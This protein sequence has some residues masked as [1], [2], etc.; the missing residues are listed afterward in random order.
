MGINRSVAG[1]AIV[2]ALVAAGC[3]A[4]PTETEVS[5][6][7][8]ASRRNNSKTEQSY[9]A[10][11]PSSEVVPTS[12]ADETPEASD[13]TDDVEAVTDSGAA[14]S[15]FADESAEVAGDDA[16]TTMALG[17]STSDLSDETSAPLDTEPPATGNVCRETAGLCDPMRECAL[18]DCDFET[19][20]KSC[21]Y[22]PGRTYPFMC[23]RAANFE[24]Y[25]PCDADDV[26]AP[27]S[28]CISK[29]TLLKDGSFYRR[30]GAVC[31]ETCRRDAD[32]GEGEWCAQATD[33]NNE[34]IPDLR[35]C[36]RHCDAE[37]DCYVGE[38]DDEVRCS[39][40]VEGGLPSTYECSRA[41]PPNPPTDPA[42]GAQSPN[43]TDSAARDGTNGAELSASFTLHSLRAE[44]AAIECIIG[45]D[46]QA[47]EDCVDNTC[48]RRCE[49]DDECDGTQCVVVSGR[50]TCGA[51][52]E[53]PEGAACALLP[54]NCGCATGETCVL[55][56]GSEPMCSAPGPN[57]AMS[58]CNDS[59]DCDSG[60][61]C[62]GGLCRPLCDPEAQPCNP[63]YG[64]CVLSATRESGDIH[65]CAGTCDP[66]TAPRC[67]PGAVC[68]PG[69]DANHHRQSLCVAERAA[70]SPRS[71]GETCTEDHDCAPGLGCSASAVC[72]SWCRSD[73]DCEGGRVCKFDASIIGPKV[74]RYGESIDDIV[75]LC[76]SPTR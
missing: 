28:V 4:A 54:S 47:K 61:S 42:S 45:D 51:P 26:C 3:S 59:T 8:V 14:A 29:V 48:R 7:G 31:R 52:C 12:V 69:F 44:G 41:R 15:T 66:V 17:A 53:K 6:S 24:P 32:C 30:S 33:E 21:S 22:T 67:G 55:G 58:W 34:P 73:G 1:W 36:H 50:G 64:E 35:V 49:K 74:Q 75:G 20:G 19:T 62:I 60:L 18:S 25:R 40:S 37:S 16:G 68:L 63:Q 38:G 10:V 56:P 65:A 76:G 39:S 11:D 71:A 9:V 46:C 27:G 23:V 5:G 2:T 43:D 13:T 57:G 70:Q 72:Q